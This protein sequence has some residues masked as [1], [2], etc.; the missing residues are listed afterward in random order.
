MFYFF[1]IHSDPN[2]MILERQVGIMHK[3]L[4]KLSPEGILLI[5]CWELSRNA[6]KRMNLKLGEINSDGVS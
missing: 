4:R 5:D 1:S 3:V 2:F 6:T